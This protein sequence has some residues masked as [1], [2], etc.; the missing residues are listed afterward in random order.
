LPGWANN[1]NTCKG[2]S[3]K[4]LLIVFVVT[5]VFF[6]WLRFDSAQWRG[7][8]SQSPAVVGVSTTEPQQSG[9]TKPAQAVAESAQSSDVQGAPSKDKPSLRIIGLVPESER[10]P[11]RAESSQPADDIPL[12][13]LAIS[14]RVLTRTGKPVS[15]ME[16]TATASRLFEQGR[17]KNVPRGARQRRAK[18]GHDGAYRFENLANGEYQVSTVATERYARAFLQVRAGVDAVDLVVMGHRDIRVRGIVTTSGSEPLAGVVVRA[19]VQDAREVRT[20]RDG[21]YVFGVKLPDNATVLAVRATRAGYKD[22]DAQLTT[23]PEDMTKVREL[24]IVMEP[25]TDSELAEVSGKVTG[26]DREPVA[27]QRMQF[28][29]ARVRQNYR[30]TT[31]TDGTFSFGGVEPGDDYMLTVNAA[32]AYNDYFQN[33]IDVPKRGLTLNIQLEERENGVL[34]G[35]MVDVMGNPVA[36]FSLVLQTKARSFYNQQVIGDGLGRFVIEKAPAGELLLK[37]KSN[38]YYSITGIRIAPDAEEQV[39]VVLDSGSYEI[40]G[41]VVNK[42]GHPVAVPNI[43]LTWAHEQD[44]IRTTARRTAAADEQGNFRFTQLGPGRHRLTINAAGYHSVTLNHDV[45]MQ[46]SDVVVELKAK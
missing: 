41:Q 15:G 12:G 45:A 8:D 26:P 24:N 29:S 42:D 38:P 46:G 1:I 43:S 9:E 25:D 32:D 17:S 19:N 18:T 6:V 20:N 16:I 23:D 35:H 27:G 5:V 30:A 33:N 40:R 34:R 31:K 3:N 37:T 22:R 44:G 28:S 10:A 2:F 7:S 4:A 21:A 14:G 39:T 36:D 11:S 13:D